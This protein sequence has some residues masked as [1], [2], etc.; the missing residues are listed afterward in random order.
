MSLQWTE[1][2][3]KLVVFLCILNMLLECIFQFKK[4]SLSFI[5]TEVQSIT[6]SPLSSRLC[7]SNKIVAMS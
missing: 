4:I 3:N 2:G 6:V 7:E 1:F 5:K